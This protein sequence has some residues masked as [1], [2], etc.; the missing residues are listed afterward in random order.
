MKLGSLTAGPGAGAAVYGGPVLEGIDWREHRINPSEINDRVQNDTH[1]IQPWRKLRPETGSTINFGVR[2]KAYVCTKD[3]LLRQLATRRLGTDNYT[4]KHFLHSFPKLPKNATKSEIFD[5]LSNVS[6]YACG[7]AVYVPPPHTM[8]ADGDKGAWWADLPDHC[9]NEL[10]YYDNA[11]C[12]A[13]TMSSTGLSD[14]PGLTHLL[15]TRSGYGILWQMAFFAGHPTLS[16]TTMEFTV[17]TQPSSMS[18]STYKKEWEYYLHM[19]YIRGVFL[20]DRY[21]LER[22]IAGMNGVYNTNLKPL[23][24]GVLRRLEIDTY[25]PMHWQPAFLLPYI[26][27]LAEFN[28]IHNLNVAQTPKEFAESRGNRRPSNSV[29]SLSTTASTSK[30]V[31]IRQIDDGTLDD[32]MYHSICAIMAGDPKT[33]DLCG[34]LEHLIASCPRLRTL[35]ADPHKVK[36]LLRTIELA[37]AG[38]GGTQSQTSSTAASTLNSL[39][40]DNR[41]S[42]P[43]TSNRTSRLVRQLQA[44]DTD[45]DLSISRL[46]DDEGSVD[47]QDFR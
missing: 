33:C 34:S 21:F 7:V 28:G 45:D 39:I 44:D 13:L 8:V 20:S 46:T 25:V 19:Q 22:F 43:P 1:T 15:Q 12:Q 36:R 24:L 27:S 14:T 17:P 5:F 47:G 2:F 26:A 29:R 16:P 35:L 37:R 18:L 38:R 41:S 40:G 30:L 11:L 9:H 6:Q 32:E 42:T 31:D 4:V 3:D 10:A 23:L